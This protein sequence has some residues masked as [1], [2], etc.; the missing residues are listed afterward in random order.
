MPEDKDLAYRLQKIVSN[1]PDLN[2]RAKIFLEQTLIPTLEAF[3]DQDLDFL[4]IVALS[5]DLAIQDWFHTD[6]DNVL[7][8]ASGRLQAIAGLLSAYALQSDMKPS[9]EDCEACNC[10]DCSPTEKEGAN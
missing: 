7:Y 6:Y 9:E 2:S 4:S 8:E 1:I 5:H 10:P 3:M